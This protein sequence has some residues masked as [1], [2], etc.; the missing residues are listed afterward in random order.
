MNAGV[1]CTCGCPIL[2]YKWSQCSIGSNI[3][4][5]SVKSGSESVVTDQNSTFDS[6][7]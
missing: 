2:W 7:N 1:R 3:V 4:T 6:L 5:D